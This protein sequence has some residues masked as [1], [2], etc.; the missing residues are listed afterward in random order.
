MDAASL[1]VDVEAYWRGVR[2]LRRE[3]RKS[4][5]KGSLSPPRNDVDGAKCHA[6]SKFEN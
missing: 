1:R 5:L 4:K 2:L 3:E 6:G